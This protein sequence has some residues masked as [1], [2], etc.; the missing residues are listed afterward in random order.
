M[1]LDVEGWLD[2][3]LISLEVEEE[4][5]DLSLEQKFE[6]VLN[7]VERRGVASTQGSEEASTGLID[8]ATDDADRDDMREE[9]EKP[10]KQEPLPLE[11]TSPP[12]P[13]SLV[14]GRRIGTVGLSVESGGNIPGIGP[15]VNGGRPGGDLGGS[16]ALKRDILACLKGEGGGGQ[17]AM[18]PCPALLSQLHNEELEEDGEEMTEEKKEERRFALLSLAL[19]EDR[20]SLLERVP[21]SF[22]SSLCFVLCAFSSLSAGEAA[23]VL[24]LHSVHQL[25]SGWSGEDS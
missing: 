16:L 6:L 12:P 5:Q 21:Q 20:M 1:S 19:K 7:L 15:N 14:S 18:A 23:T 3:L 11:P 22:F 2:R 13:S 24:F 9:V 4:E 25:I 8:D 10:I 17:G